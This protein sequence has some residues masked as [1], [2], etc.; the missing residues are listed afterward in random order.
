MLTLQNV[1]CGYHS[2]VDIVKDI[3]MEVQPGE[4]CCIIG[5]NGAGKSTL[6][7]S[8]AH[9]LPYRGE[10][11]INDKNVFSMKRKEIGRTVAILSQAGSMYFP[12]SVF[13]TVMLGRYSYSKGPFAAASMHD[14]EAV[15]QALQ[16][17]GLIELKGRLISELS[18][19]QLQRVFL[20]RAIAQDPEIILL[21]EPTNHLD[22]KY[23][24][25]V[26][27]HV[28]NWARENNKMVVAV[29]HDLNLV[30][31][32]ADKVILMHEGALYSSG[33]TKEVLTNDSL[34]EI[35]G[36]N[37]KEWMLGVLELWQ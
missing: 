8:L 14:V 13:D 27:D 6:L 31:K 28:K 9:I 5:P 12:Y 25:E 24:I 22:F 16:T 21:D 23:Q 32:Y 33:H 20:A 26:L 35:Y 10:I 17:V 4:L 15:N 3:T 11:R 36:I 37:V 1:Y 2:Q 30:Q 7:K 18:G 19:G 34:H 29:L